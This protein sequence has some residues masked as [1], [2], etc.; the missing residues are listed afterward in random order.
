MAPT[1]TYCEDRAIEYW[2]RVVNH[3]K[4]RLRFWLVTAKFKNL[5]FI[6]NPRLLLGDV[7]TELGQYNRFKNVALEENCMLRSECARYNEIPIS[8]CRD[9]DAEEDWS[10][11]N[12]KLKI[13]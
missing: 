10:K 12:G 7:D 1:S 6:S 5:G 4:R 13:I 2:F 3:E 11:N 9:K 8:V